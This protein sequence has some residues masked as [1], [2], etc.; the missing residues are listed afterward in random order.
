MPPVNALC[1]ASAL[2]SLPRMRNP[3]RLL[4]LPTAAVLS[5]A[6]V[7]GAAPPA[8]AAAAIY[9]VSGTVYIDAD[10]DGTYSVG[11]LPL[12]GAGVDLFTSAEAAATGADP[13]RSLTTGRLGTYAAS[14]LTAGTYYTAVRADGY[15]FQQEPAAVKVS[16]T[17]P[18]GIADVPATPQTTL[19]ASVFDDANGNGT[20]DA[21]ET[22]VDGKTL[23]FIDVLRTQQAIADGSLGSIDIGSAILG[24]IGGT[25]DL[26]GAIQFRTTSGGQPITYQDVP[27]GAYVIMRSPFNLTLTDLLGDISRITA[28][29]DLLSSGDAAGLLSMDP[30][31]LSTGDISTTPRNEYIQQ[32]ASALSSAVRVVDEA[33]TEKLLGTELSDQVS[34]VTGTVAQV[35]NLIA[36]LPATHFVAVDRWGGGW[37]LTNL[38]VKRTTSYE[39][40]VRKPV[41]ITGSV[42]NDSNANGNKDTL[43]LAES[44]TLTAYAADGTVLSSTTTPSLAGSYTVRNL[45]YD[46]DIYLALSGTSKSPSVRWDGEV[47]PALAGLTLIG[48]YHLA[49]DGD[50]SAI[51]QNIGLATLTAPTATVG[52]VDANGSATL[53]L[54]NKGSAALAVQYA[55]NDAAP[56]ATT[57]PAKTLLTSAGT[58]T[59]TLTGLVPGAN[60]VTI[61]WS[62]GVYRGD[63]LVVEVTR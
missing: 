30:A 3:T 11:D 17:K 43:D 6:L 37:Q 9:T 22:A 46:T 63:R 50:V 55:V 60:L 27:S 62:A 10:A 5:A 29:I 25:V 13:V 26:G 51:S 4:A 34:K 45:P 61:D 14:Q 12:S 35:A 52:A 8:S 32:L 58:R 40:G 59:V 21:Q 39:F 33:D 56:I 48:K 20:W 7:V 15:R 16:L 28:F 49:D 19:S 54:S 36:A 31:L 44:V 2:A 41:T 57:V 1:A 23:I 18:L 38:R 24:A 42:F 53:T 47:P